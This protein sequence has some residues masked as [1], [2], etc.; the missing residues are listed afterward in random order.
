MIAAVGA[1]AFASLMRRVALMK[2]APVL[3]LSAVR[4]GRQLMDALDVSQATDLRIVAAAEQAGTVDCYRKG[5]GDRG[6]QCG[7]N[8]RRVHQQFAADL[9]PEGQAARGDLDG[10]ERRFGLGDLDRVPCVNRRL[11]SQRSRRC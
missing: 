5:R 1:G 4:D 8:V 6:T 2:R 7:L 3:Q 10:P 9:E 11:A